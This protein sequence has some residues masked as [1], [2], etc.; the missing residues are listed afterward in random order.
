VRTYA[1]E[2]E[3]YTL[4]PPPDEYAIADEV[5][6]LLAAA[7]RAGVERFHLYRHS[8]GGAVALAFTA[9]HPERVLSLLLDEPAFDFSDEMRADSS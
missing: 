8:G 5:E 6:G 4:S 3:V 7:R 1:K 2:L 9:A